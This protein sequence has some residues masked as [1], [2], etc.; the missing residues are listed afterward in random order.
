MLS[1][2]EIA[3]PQKNKKVNLQYSDECLAFGFY[4]CGDDTNPKPFKRSYGA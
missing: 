1:L 4:W 3:P 2:F